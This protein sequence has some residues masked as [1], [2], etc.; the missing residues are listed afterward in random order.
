M[1]NWYVG[2]NDDP[3]ALAH[4][5]VLGMR[6]GVRKSRGYATA[7]KAAKHRKKVALQKAG[8]NKE[9]R[10]QAKA[11]YKN[12][13]V[14]ERTKALNKLYPKNS[15][16]LNKKIASDSMAK[17]LTKSYLMGSYGAAKYDRDRTEGRGRFVSGITGKAYD[18]ANKYLLNIPTNA[19][20]IG[21][22]RARVKKRRA[23]KK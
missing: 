13:L 20:Q 6:W 23:A 3:N 4:Y 16:A 7:R 18:V 9:L 19:E 5:G 1:S 21:Q 14:N 10:K 8:K 22:Y 12:T 11:T 17:S 2:S 15:K